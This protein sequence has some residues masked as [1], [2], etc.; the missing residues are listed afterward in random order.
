MS[1][2]ASQASAVYL[3]DDVCRILKMSRRTLERLRRLAIGR[4]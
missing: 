2:A 3:M 1:G 4:W